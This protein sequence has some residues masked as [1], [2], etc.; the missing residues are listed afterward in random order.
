[1]NK[2]GFT[3]S[4]LLGVIVVLAIIITIAT[5]SI[6]SIINRSKNRVSKEMEDTLKD[7]A[8]TYAIDNRLSSPTIINVSDLDSAGL[9]ED[10]TGKCSGVTSIRISYANHDYVVEL[11]GHCNN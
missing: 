10:K 2:K 9:F 1:M 11:E 3:L 5:A 6:A 4:E 7:A 8:V